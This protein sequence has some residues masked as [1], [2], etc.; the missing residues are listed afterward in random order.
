MNSRKG[1]TFLSWGSSLL[2][3]CIVGLFVWN[4]FYFTDFYLEKELD[5]IS[6]VWSDQ[7]IIHDSRVVDVHVQK[8]REKLKS[9]AI[10]TIRGK[11]YK[12]SEN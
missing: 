7:E 10:I 3:V 6:E 1:F 2:Y 12:W 8:L 4:L 11:A 9:Y 5:Y